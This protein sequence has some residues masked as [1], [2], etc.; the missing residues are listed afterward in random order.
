MLGRKIYRQLY[1][2]KGVPHEPG[3][4]G[5]VTDYENAYWREILPQRTQRVAQQ[6]VLRSFAKFEEK[7]G[8]HEAAE[9]AKPWVDKR[10]VGRSICKLYQHKD[11]PHKPGDNAGEFCLPD[12]RLASAPPCLRGKMDLVRTFSPSIKTNL[13]VCMKIP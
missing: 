9:T 4:K 2:H 8:R 13:V 12:Y 11:G 10:F 1:L 7:Y 6:K 5:W 3:D